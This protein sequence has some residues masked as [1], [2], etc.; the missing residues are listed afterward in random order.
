MADSAVRRLG[1]RLSTETILD[2]RLDL[3]LRLFYL[4]P[5]RESGRGMALTR[6]LMLPFP[7]SIEIAVGG[8]SLVQLPA[9]GGTQLNRS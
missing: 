2:Y 5:M 8:S 7:P 3:E 4:P 9:N 1:M 6:T